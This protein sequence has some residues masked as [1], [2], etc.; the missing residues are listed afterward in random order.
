MEAG[1]RIHCPPGQIGE[2]AKP[3]IPIAGAGDARTRWLNTNYIELI[4]DG[5]IVD[6]NR[7]PLP[8]D[9]LIIDRRFSD[10]LTA[11]GMEVGCLQAGLGYR[12]GQDRA[13][14][15]GETVGLA[16]RVRNVC[17]ETVQFNYVWAFLVENP[18][19]VLD[20]DGKQILFDRISA[21][22][23]HA[24]KTVDLAPGKEVELYE[25]KLRPSPVIEV[26]PSKA[27]AFVERLLASGK[28][29]VQYERLTGPD[30]DEIV[31]KLATGKLEL[32][33]YPEQPA[34]KK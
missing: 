5:R 6:L 2:L 9:M 13:Y 10:D 30:V 3:G 8:P 12:Q 17:K 29:S 4:V 31:S 28:I 24:P 26:S 34:G 19:T 27:E 21:M 20:G 18:P 32:E 1:V 22:G 33:I 7:I 25:L 23:E 11:W 16:V 15:H 14:S